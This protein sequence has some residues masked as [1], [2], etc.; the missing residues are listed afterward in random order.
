M[1]WSR[2]D[3]T[4]YDHPKLMNLPDRQRNEAAGLRDRCLS[5]SNRHL[6]DGHIP[7]SVLTLLGARASVVDAL[8]TAGLFE[9]ER[10]GIYIHDY[11]DF[12]ESRTEILERR[13]KLIEAGRMGGLAKKRNAE[14]NASDE[15]SEPLASASEVLADRHPDRSSDRHSDRHSDGL[16]IGKRNGSNGPS[17]V[18]APPRAQRAH[19]PEAP[20]RNARPSPSPSPGREYEIGSVP[21]DVHHAHEGNDEWGAD[22]DAV[23]GGSDEGTLREARRR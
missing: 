23:F 10:T 7:M 2:L 6:A 9:R 20:A 16:A 18:V 13:A 3:D 8:V 4:W 19:A 11:P 14:R 1:P 17:E 15:P 12:N 5:W 22:S 21:P